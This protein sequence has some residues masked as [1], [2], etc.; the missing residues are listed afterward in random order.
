VEKICCP[1]GAKTERLGK[2][3]TTIELSGKEKGGP[4]TASSFAHKA[5]IA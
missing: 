5:E 2:E 1:E 3:Q 4:K